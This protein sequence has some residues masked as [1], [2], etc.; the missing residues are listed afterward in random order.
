M[1]YRSSLRTKVIFFWQVHRFFIRSQD[2]GV[3]ALP[4]TWK[5]SYFAEWAHAEAG[6]VDEAKL[7]LMLFCCTLLSLAI[8]W[9]FRRFNS[10]THVCGQWLSK[11]FN[12]PIPL[13]Q[14]QM[15]V[16]VQLLCVKFAA[17]L[18]SKFPCAFSHMQNSA[19]TIF[20]C[21]VCFYYPE[22][23]GWEDV[24]LTGIKWFLTENC[25]KNN[26]HQRAV[27]SRASDSM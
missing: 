4:A 7:P 9:V 24:V 19:A 22:E 20:A 25:I 5:Y 6:T 12:F 13:K 15:L 27:N 16:R 11:R 21:S 17:A 14:T 3:V 26:S 18:L 10:A 23:M 1:G 2:A 8:I